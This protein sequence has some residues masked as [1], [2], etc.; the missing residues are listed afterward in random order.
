MQLAKRMRLDGVLDR[1]KVPFLVTHGEKDRQIPL[2]YAHQTHDQ[3]VNSPARTLKI[4]ADREGGRS[5]EH[6]SELQS[7]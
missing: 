6:T 7:R 5:E 2:K 1:I 4:F 3:L